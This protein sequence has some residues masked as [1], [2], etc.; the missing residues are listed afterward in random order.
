M[1]I[2][3]LKARSDSLYLVIMEK[4][5]ELERLADEYEFVQCKIK[6]EAKR[7]ESLRNEKEEPE[8]EPEPEEG[9]DT[10]PPRYKE[11][12]SLGEMLKLLETEMKQLEETAK[13]DFKMEDL[14][15]NEAIMKRMAEARASLNTIRGSKSE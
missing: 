14:E 3:E 4:K 10:L 11:C 15:D 13:A 12:K 5:D 7:L 1:S 8:P 9:P 6:D 2:N